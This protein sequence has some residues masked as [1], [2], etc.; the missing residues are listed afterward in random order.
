MKVTSV[1]AYA[2][3]N[4]INFWKKYLKKKE[5]KKEENVMIMFNTFDSLF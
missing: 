1:L 4:F 3:E 2:I 5:E